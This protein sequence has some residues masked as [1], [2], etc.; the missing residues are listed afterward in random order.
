MESQHRKV[1]YRMKKRGMYWTLAGAETMSRI[2]V[3]NYEDS[4]RELFFGTWREDYEKFISL[5][6]VSAYTI[7]KT[8][9]VHNKVYKKLYNNNLCKKR[10]FCATIKHKMLARY[11]KMCYNLLKLIE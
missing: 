1:T 2:I 10:S 8:I 5:E 7:K 4:L 6:E 9:E 11:V 3:L